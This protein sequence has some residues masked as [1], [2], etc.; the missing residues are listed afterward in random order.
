MYAHP[1][2]AA[3]P[4]VP[5]VFQASSSAVGSGRP[6]LALLVL[7]V[8]TLFFPASAICPAR[9]HGRKLPDFSPSRMI[10]L[11]PSALVIAFLA[12][13]DI[14]ASAMVADK[15]IE[16]WHRPNAEAGPPRA[17]AISAGADSLGLPPPGAICPHS[18]QHQRPVGKD[19]GRGGWS[20]A[21]VILL[22]MLP[23]APLAGYLAMPALAATADHHRLEHDRAA[24]MGRVCK[25]QGKATFCSW[26]LTLVL[27]VLADL[28]VAIGVG[29]SPVVFAL[30]H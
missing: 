14:A 11:L 16:G 22:V 19:P 12:G 1:D 30:S 25:R 2:R 3:A 21:V 6:S 27:T 7:P 5:T 26:L 10:E 28:T 15:M 29:R 17:Y 18:H 20:I 23:A 24:Q 8:D 13:V 9:C 4:A